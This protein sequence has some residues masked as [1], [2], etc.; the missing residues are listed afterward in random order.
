M[1]NSLSMTEKL[2]L[3]AVHPEKGGIRM[4]SSNAI[5]YALGGALMCEL[6]S[7]QNIRVENK[8]VYLLNSRSKNPL[9][10]LV[11]EK[12]VKH[13]NQMK[14][15]A[16]ITKLSLSASTI[17]RYLQGSLIRKRLIRLEEKRFLFFRWKKPV[18]LNKQVVH[19]LQDEI[20]NW[21]STG[22]SGEEEIMLLSLLQPAGLMGSIFPDRNKRKAA[23]NELKKMTADSQV[24]ESVSAAIAASNAVA[25]AVSV[26]VISAAAS[27]GR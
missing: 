8:R 14:I 18:L 26:A 27:Q 10:V 9:H 13:K 19:K 7:R 24:S 16:L 21:I 6:V 5:R 12:L 23:G 1:E 4:G 17:R 3:L 2:Y 11:L 15:S 22:T 20:R 25:A